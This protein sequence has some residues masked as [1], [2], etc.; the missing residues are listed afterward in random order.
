MRCSNTSPN[1]FV[2]YEA[3]SKE[4]LDIIEKELQTEINKI[5]E[6]IKG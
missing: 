1:V 3:D 2:R 4:N 5:L 6:E